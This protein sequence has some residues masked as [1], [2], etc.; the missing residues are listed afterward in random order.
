LK[1]EHFVMTAGA[2]LALLGVGA[3]SFEMTGA[4]VVLWLLALFVLGHGG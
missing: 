3:T 2:F 4:A 1:E